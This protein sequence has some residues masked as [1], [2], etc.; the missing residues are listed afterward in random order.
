M[1]TDG[2]QVMAIAHSELKNKKMSPKNI[3]KPQIGNLSIIIC[4]IKKMV[5]VQKSTKDM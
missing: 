1:F 3:F 4:M 2:R 5:Y